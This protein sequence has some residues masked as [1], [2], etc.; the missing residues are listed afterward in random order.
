MGERAR[1]KS[2]PR[3]A[4]REEMGVSP[5]DLARIAYGPAP[6]SAVAATPLAGIS[7]DPLEQ[8]GKLRPGDVKVLC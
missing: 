1:G 5:P 6:S 7:P 8:M 2:R 3:G 4:G